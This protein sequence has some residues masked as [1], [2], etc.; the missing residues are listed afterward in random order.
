[1][2]QTSEEAESDDDSTVG[3]SEPEANVEICWRDDER[4]KDL[5]AQVTHPADRKTAYCI[6]RYSPPK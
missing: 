2:D 5:L 1:M 3:A 6:W 4:V